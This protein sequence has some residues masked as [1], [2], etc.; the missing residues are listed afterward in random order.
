MPAESYIVPTFLISPSSLISLFQSRPL[1]WRTLTSLVFHLAYS[2]LPLPSVHLWEVTACG[3]QSLIVF[4][5]VVYLRGRFWTHSFGLE[6][7]WLPFWTP[8]A[9][10]D[11]DFW[12]DGGDE[13]RLRKRRNS[14]RPRYLMSADRDLSGGFRDAKLVWTLSCRVEVCWRKGI[15]DKEMDQGTSEMASLIIVVINVRCKWS[16]NEV[17]ADCVT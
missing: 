10:I 12:N 2:H 1:S 17:K 14:C 3:G 4:V 5:G 15:E 11:G 6:S 7:P 13:D 16:Q 8:R 9:V